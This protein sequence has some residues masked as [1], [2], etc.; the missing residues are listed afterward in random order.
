MI[1]RTIFQF[2]FKEM[3]FS[4]KKISCVW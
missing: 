2:E 1:F 3:H 4:M